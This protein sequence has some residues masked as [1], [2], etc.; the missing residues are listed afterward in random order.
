MAVPHTKIWCISFWYHP[1]FIACYC[2]TF[3]LSFFTNNTRFS[4]SFSEPPSSPP[5]QRAPVVAGGHGFGGQLRGAVSPP[6]SGAAPI[7][8]QEPAL[9][10]SGL[11]LT[12]PRRS[13]PWGQ[14]AR[15]VRRAHRLRVRYWSAISTLS[16]YWSS[17]HVTWDTIDKW[18]VVQYSIYC[19]YT[20]GRSVRF[21]FVYVPSRLVIMCTLSKTLSRCRRLEVF[22]GPLSS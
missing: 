10:S 6:I 7:L 16:L 17:W 3:K 18:T 9:A 5:Q 12:T 11:K 1:L 21:A 8:Q 20:V 2:I 19:P 13:L 15:Q 14:G 22:M 4:D